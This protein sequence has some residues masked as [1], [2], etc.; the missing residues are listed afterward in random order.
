[1]LVYLDM[2]HVLL[3]NKLLETLAKLFMVCFRL[4]KTS[5]HILLQKCTIFHIV[6]KTL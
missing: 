2:K 5:S 4:S 3:Q 1:M 6:L